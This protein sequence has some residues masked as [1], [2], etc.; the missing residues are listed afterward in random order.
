MS[1]RRVRTILLAEDNPDHALLVRIAAE[2]AD[3]SLDVRVVPD[4]VAALAY[5]EGKD[6]FACRDAFPLPNL[7]ILD[8]AMPHLDGFGVLEWMRGRRDLA[9]VPVVVLTS[10]DSPRDER[11]ALKLGARAF[12]TKPADLDGLGVQVRE[13]VARWTR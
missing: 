6:P 11:R 10:S 4:G 9:T 7:V 3:P 2:R 5:L 1:D 12:H 13:I 8:L